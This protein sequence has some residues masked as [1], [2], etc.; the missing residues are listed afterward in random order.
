MAEIEPQDGAEL[1]LSN[2]PVVAEAKRR[3]DLVCEWESSSRERFI[4]DIK[5]AE[6]DSD[7]AYQWPNAIRRARDV[8]QNLA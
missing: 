8:D 3:W 4:N 6:A 2:D 7:N 1:L 5:F